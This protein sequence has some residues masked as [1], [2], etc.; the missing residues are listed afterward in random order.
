MNTG[1]KLRK[2]KEGSAELYVYAGENISKKL[3]VFY[4]PVMKLN[5]DITI[6]LLRQFPPLRLCDP[7]AGTGVRAIRFS[8]ELKP[9][10]ITAN[11]MSDRAVRLIRKNMDINAVEFP[12]YNKDANLFLLESE[13]F[14][15]IDLDV[16]GSPNFMLDS[17]VKRL[18][19][20]GVLAVTATDTAALCGTSPKACIRKYWA[21]PSKS[22]MM[23]E[24]G[25][26]ILIRKIQLI[27]AQYDKALLPVLSYSKDHYFRIFFKCSKGKSSVDSL[28]KSHGLF[29]GAG[30]LW[31]GSLYD[32]RLLEGMKNSLA[33]DGVIGKDSSVLRFTSLLL[34]ESLADSIGFFD[35]HDV[36]SKNKINPVPKKEDILEKLQERGFKSSP[37]HFSGTGIKSDI[38]HRE[39]VDL[40][41][42]LAKTK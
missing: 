36:C 24:T 19:R 38:S 18:G 2:I 35:V 14:D 41:K 23:H 27:G 40:L 11:D 21:V 39:L 13:G 5:R 17:S 34:S 37:T 9:K 32:R 3:P 10:S 20:G 7:L 42:E 8:K 15:F 4:N 28:L 1:Y 6:I 26:R 29:N 22:H 12:V 31:T 30:P 25:L 33:K 16:F